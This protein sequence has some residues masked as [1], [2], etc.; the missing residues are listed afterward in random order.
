MLDSILYDA[1]Y[2]YNVRSISFSAKAFVMRNEDLYNISQY[3]V[4]KHWQNNVKKNRPTFDV[5]VDAGSVRISFSEKYV[6][7]FSDPLYLKQVITPQMSESAGGDYDSDNPDVQEL[8]QSL[9]QVSLDSESRRPS[10][11]PRLENLEPISENSEPVEDK[12]LFQILN[13]S[14]ESVLPL[15][16]VSETSDAGMNDLYQMTT[17]TS[18]AD[19]VLALPT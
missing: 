6:A 16:S 10:K 19:S 12:D 5:V 7:Q 15:P 17:S 18:C 4:P 1:Y 11:R 14:A 2:H 8:S 13:L 9:S 3:R